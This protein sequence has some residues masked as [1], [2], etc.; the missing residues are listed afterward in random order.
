MQ[1]KTLSG[2]SEI[3]LGGGPALNH[4]PCVFT[5]ASFGGREDSAVSNTE[6]VFMLHVT[7]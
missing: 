4:A 5:L 1:I 3:R 2:N 6:L 7:V